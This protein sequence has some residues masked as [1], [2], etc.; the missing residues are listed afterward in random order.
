VGAPVAVPTVAHGAP[1]PETICLRAGTP[2]VHPRHAIH[3]TTPMSAVQLAAV[4]D[5]V[6]GS[7]A[8]SDATDARVAATPA[9][10]PTLDVNVQLH[11]IRGRHKREHRVKWRNAAALFRILRDGF[12]GAQSPGISEPMGV[13]FVLKRISVTRNDRWYHAFPMSRADRQMRR[14][15]HRGTAQTLNIYLKAFPKVRGGVLLGHSR[16]PWQYRGHRTLDGVEVNVDGMPGGRARGFNLGDTVIHETGHWFGLL[17]SFQGGCDSY[18]DGVADT[19]AELSTARACGD[20][21]NLCDP[22][23]ILPAPAGPGYYDPAFNFMEYTPDAC[24]R[25]FTP[26]QHKLAVDRF[27]RYR[28]G[29]R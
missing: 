21:S 14:H 9:V 10:L 16:F 18:S 27:M 1:A 8:P 20:P 22:D 3:D 17:H 5:Q 13:N 24:M 2:I 29:R 11:I 12:N 7:T 23:Q 4:D 19:P 15:L 26:G 28:Y 25:M 6:A